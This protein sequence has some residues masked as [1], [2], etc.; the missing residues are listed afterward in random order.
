M[1]DY[2]PYGSQAEAD[3]AYAAWI[4]SW[5]KK[6]EALWPRVFK[7]EKRGEN[8]REVAAALLRIKYNGLY[9]IRQADRDLITAFDDS[10][11]GF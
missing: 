3:V 1:N 6:A 8:V 5:E 2:G 11:A 10:C 9:G 7:A 4:R